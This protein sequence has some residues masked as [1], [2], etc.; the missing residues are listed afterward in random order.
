[1]ALG[2]GGGADYG[3]SSGDG[4]KDDATIWGDKES[5][6]KIVV[7]RLFFGVVFNKKTVYIYIYIY[8]CTVSHL[9]SA[10]Q[11]GKK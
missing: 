6:V 3:H 11:F 5:L 8:S 1:M 2:G 9:K 10:K 4:L 7:L